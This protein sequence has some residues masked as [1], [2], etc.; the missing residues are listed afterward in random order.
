M[1]DSNGFSPLLYLQKNCSN[2]CFVLLFRMISKEEFLG[3]AP[4]DQVIIH[5]KK[6]SLKVG[7]FYS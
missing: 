3:E 1:K 7:K 2:F 4:K 5:F 6:Y